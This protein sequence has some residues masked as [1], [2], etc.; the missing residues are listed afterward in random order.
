MLMATSRYGDADGNGVINVDDVLNVLG[1]YGSNN[2]DGDI[3]GDGVC[4]VDD[5][6]EV[7]S[8]FGSEC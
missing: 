5:V 6:L 3:N 7:L 4:N 2:G 1:S 8:Y